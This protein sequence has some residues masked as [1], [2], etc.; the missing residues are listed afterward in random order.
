VANIK[1]LQNVGE[2]CAHQ[3]IIVDNLH[4][5][6]NQEYDSLLRLQPQCLLQRVRDALLLKDMN[7]LASLTYTLMRDIEP[8]M[9]WVLLA[10]NRQKVETNDERTKKRKLDI[11]DDYQFVLREGLSI[12]Q[13]FSW[14]QFGDTFVKYEA[15]RKRILELMRRIA[16][17]YGIV[18]GIC[19]RLAMQAAQRAFDCFDGAYSQ[20]YTNEKMILASRAA[21]KLSSVGITQLSD[22]A[23]QTVMFGNFSYNLHTPYISY[24]WTVDMGKLIKSVVMNVTYAVS[25]FNTFTLNI[26]VF[27]RLRL[28]LLCD[29]WRHNLA[30]QIQING[31]ANQ[32]RYGI[33]T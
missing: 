6:C 17:H 13:L 7:E 32:I 10:S 29:F 27:M 30:Q 18:F 24:A 1:A 33:P 26:N 23:I 2:E 22:D 12:Q 16:I 8:R 11:D 5:L 14:M 21:L 9:L 15:S 28:P 20:I 19:E 4:V 31:N 25:Y 3:K